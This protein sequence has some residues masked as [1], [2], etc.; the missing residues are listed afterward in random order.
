MGED[1]LILK[2][3]FNKASKQKFINI[4]KGCNIQDGDYALVKKVLDNNK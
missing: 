3:R 4:P 2:V 1:K